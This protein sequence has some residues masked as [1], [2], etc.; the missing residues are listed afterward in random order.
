MA[1]TFKF[2]DGDGDRVH[3]YLDTMMHHTGITWITPNHVELTGAPATLIDWILG[4]GR[5]TRV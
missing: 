1:E 5:G 2:E 4:P 3:G